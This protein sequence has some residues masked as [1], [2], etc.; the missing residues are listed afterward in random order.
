MKASI[1]GSHDTIPHIATVYNIDGSE[2]DHVFTW[3]LGQEYAQRGFYV[4]ALADDEYMTRSNM[5]RVFT[6]SRLAFERGETL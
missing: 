2:H 1:D 5:Q 3:E 6:E 4:R